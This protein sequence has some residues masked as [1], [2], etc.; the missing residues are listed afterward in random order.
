MTH[1]SPISCAI[2]PQVH[3]PTPSKHFSF[4]SIPIYFPAISSYAAQPDPTS[5]SPPHRF[6]KQTLPTS[7]L[8]SFLIFS[9]FPHPS[10]SLPLPRPYQRPFQHSTHTLSLVS[11]TTKNRLPSKLVPSQ[12]AD[13]LNYASHIEHTTVFREVNANVHVVKYTINI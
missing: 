3:L 11:D 6:A 4:L 8:F 12:Y 5:Y 2:Y 10:L 9:F 13:L 1:L 7:N